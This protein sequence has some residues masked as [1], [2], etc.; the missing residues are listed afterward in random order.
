MVNPGGGRG[1]SG[2]SGIMNFS[3]KKN[4]R[5]FVRTGPSPG[6]R[7]ESGIKMYNQEDEDALFL[8]M[9]PLGI[10]IIHGKIFR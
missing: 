1:G 8:T 9:G 6:S 2:N 5:D 7:W 10:A 3:R 4:L